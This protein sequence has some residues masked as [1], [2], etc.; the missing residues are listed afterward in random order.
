MSDDL[1]LVRG[2]HQLGFG[3][4]VAYW[5]MDFLTHARSGGDWNVNGQITGLGLADFMLGRIARLE[6]G[7]PAMMPMHMM[8]LGFYTQDTWRA[9]SKL[10]LNAGLRWEP[11]LGQE[12]ENAQVYNWVPE[13]FPQQH[14]EHGLRKRP[15]RVHLPW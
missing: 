7:G 14:A 2:N 8:Y 5:A 13:N 9:T 3:A 10:T 15:R 12:L 4:N 11:F 6:H 1:S